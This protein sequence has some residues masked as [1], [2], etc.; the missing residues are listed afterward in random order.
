VVNPTGAVYAAAEL[1]DLLSVCKAHRAVVLLDT[2]FHGLEF[3]TGHVPFH[4]GAA[5]TSSQLPG[6]VLLGGVSKEF[7][8][9]G[10]RFGYA[11]S[12]D[13]TLASHV[14]AVLSEP[15]ETTQLTVRYLLEK[16]VA[17]DPQLL[18]DQTEQRRVLRHR[19]ARLATVLAQA[20][21]KPLPS[22]GG[23]FMVAAPTGLHGRSCTY[24]WEGQPKTVLLNA[25]NIAEAL[26]ASQGL[27]INNDVWT[28]IPGFC[29]FVL[30]VTDEAFEQGIAAL[31]AF[32]GAVAG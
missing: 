22:H 11:W 7:A 15:H 23:L 18:V 2:L 25:T 30:S 32:Y 29:R 1:S 17:D 19:A 4:L 20:G 6:M 24:D 3:H 13:A 9:G 14:A 10:L 26:F 27:L 12:N 5:T 21:W 31:E 8:A 28:G 16:Q